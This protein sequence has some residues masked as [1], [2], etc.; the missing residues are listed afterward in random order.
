[1][2]NATAFPLAVQTLLGIVPV[3]H[4]ETL[5]L[6]PVLPAWAPEIVVRNLRVGQA[7]ATLRFWRDDQGR[8]QWDVLHKSGTLRIVRQPPLESV[9]AGIMDR[10]KAAFESVM[11]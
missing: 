8:S 10:V 9:T 3:A 5:M 4:L 2:W 7:Q 6:D 11:P 1:L